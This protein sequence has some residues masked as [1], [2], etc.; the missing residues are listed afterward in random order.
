MC[1]RLIASLLAVTARVF[2]ESRE[3]VLPSCVGEH[4]SACSPKRARVY[5]SR[6]LFHS[7]GYGS[8]CYAE[9]SVENLW[10]GCVTTDRSPLL[11]TD[12]S[13]IFLPPRYSR[14]DVDISFRGC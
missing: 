4:A 3:E 6:L 14:L 7:P 13:T 10:E 11:A 1:T 2:E 5:N 8:A 9:I 12:Y